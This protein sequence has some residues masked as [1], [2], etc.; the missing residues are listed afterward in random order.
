MVGEREMDERQFKKRTKEMALRCIR[1]VE[2]LPKNRTAEVIG[3]QLLRSATSVGANYRAAC[4][5]KST[6]DVIA[7]LCIVEEE[8]DESLYWMELLIEAGMVEA[9]KLTSLISEI[10][11]ILAMTVASIKTLP[12]K[13]RQ[14]PQ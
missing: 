13:T 3:K 4:R 8:A 7:K 9:A 6:A 11:E 14:H 12:T 1:L 2:S 10:N 5:G